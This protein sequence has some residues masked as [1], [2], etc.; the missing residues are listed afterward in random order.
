MIASLVQQEV[1]KALKGMEEGSSAYEVNMTCYSDFADS[2]LSHYVNNVVLDYRAQKVIVVAKVINGLYILNSSSFHDLTVGVYA[3]FILVFSKYNSF[4]ALC[5]VNKTNLF[6]IKTWHSRLGHASEGV[7]SHV[8]VL[9][10]INTINKEPYV[11]CP[12]AKK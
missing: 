4:V 2:S 9:R 5:F 11:V 6:D 3:S 12:L 8:P 7:L 1:G 10:D